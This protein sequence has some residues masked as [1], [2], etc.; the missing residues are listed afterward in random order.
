MNKIDEVIRNFTQL[1]YRF[2]DKW[3]VITPNG[4]LAAQRVREN[5]LVI[6]VSMLGGQRRVY[7]H[8]I[9]AYLKYGELIFNSKKQIC[10]KDGNTFNISPDNLELRR[11]KG[12]YRWAAEKQKKPKKKPSTKTWVDYYKPPS[13]FN[14]LEIIQHILDF[15]SFGLTRKTFSI[16]P[17]DL[18]WILTKSDHLPNGKELFP[19]GNLDYK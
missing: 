17:K 18:K 16:P 10:F 15:K 9:I 11:K 2:N 14:H 7:V 6:C 1:G 5:K 4:K 8:K 3:G 13:R 19:V 12:L